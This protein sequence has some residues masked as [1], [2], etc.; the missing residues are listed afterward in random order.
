MPERP[1][2]ID[3]F[4]RR[5]SDLR[6]SITDR[7]NFRCGYC[8][9][10]EGMQ[11]LD[12]SELL[13]F[14]EI[15]RVA[16]ICVERL[17]F[18]DIRITG[19]EPT[20]RAHLPALVAMLSDLR[21]K[22]ASAFDLSM[23]TNGASLALLAGELRR[24]GLDRVNISCDSLH[25][26]R[27]AEVTRRD[28]LSRVLDGIDAALE[29]GFSKVKLNVV[30]MRGF[31]EDE[32]VDFARFGR[33]RGVEPRFIEF[34]PLDA[35]ASWSMEKVVPAS[36]TVDA[37]TK[38]FPAEV[39]DA[40][41]DP[42]RRYRYLDGKG[43]FGV[44]PSVTQPFCATCDRMRLSAEGQL[45]TCLFSTSEHDLRA[46]LR[47]GGS[48]AEIEAA[49]RTAVGQ[50]WAGHRIGKVTFIRPSRSMSQIGG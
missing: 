8:M 24:A 23:T 27:F 19:G 37:I 22:A 34:M 31:N 4:G 44:I 39:V 36:E 28:Q 33:D 17:G 16:A 40:G 50:K 42:A 35:D 41:A 10:A 11:W 14:E 12:R 46:L 48:D 43:S 32:A 45:R 5:V 49:I 20:V 15:T 13:S 26:E 25:P 9:P 1:V 6:I 7:C 21:T 3:S 29:A 38:V 18:E 47:S 30:T 2:L